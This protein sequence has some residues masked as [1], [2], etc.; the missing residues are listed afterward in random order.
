MLKE[1]EHKLTINAKISKIVNMKEIETNHDLLDLG[2]KNF[3][4]AQKKRRKEDNTTSDGN[5]NNMKIQN[6]LLRRGKF[7]CQKPQNKGEE[8]DE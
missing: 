3:F 7:D 1:K 2:G 8:S 6:M 4:D 5:E